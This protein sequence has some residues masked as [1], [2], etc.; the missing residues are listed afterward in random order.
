VTIN[1]NEQEEEAFYQGVDHPRI[2]SDYCNSFHLVRV[3]KTHCKR[4]L[5]FV[6]KVTIN[7]ITNELLGFKKN[8]IKS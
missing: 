8:S 4:R 3:A 2:I 5:G 6:L 1:I 7:I